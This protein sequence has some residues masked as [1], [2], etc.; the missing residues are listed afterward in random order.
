[1][2]D[3][4]NT[5]AEQKDITAHVYRGA[6]TQFELYFDDGVTYDYENGDFT[7]ICLSWDDAAARL[8]VEPLYGKSD[9]I[10]VKA[11]VIG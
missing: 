5:K 3:V 1:M 6:D 8:T 10:T 11:E 9:G 2:G 4:P 7:K